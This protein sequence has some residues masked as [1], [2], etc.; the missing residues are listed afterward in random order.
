MI[1]KT[2]PQYSLQL[3]CNVLINRLI[4]IHLI[5]ICKN[6]RYYRNMQYIG[7]RLIYKYTHI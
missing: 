4:V 6:I 2:M 5:S 7:L 1:D 3:L